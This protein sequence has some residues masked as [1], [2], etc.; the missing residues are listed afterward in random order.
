[1]HEG[2][3]REPERGR[4]GR[5]DADP[6]DEDLEPTGI[7]W[8]LDGYDE[9]EPVTEPTAK[10]ENSLF[11]SF[12]NPDPT[13]ETSD[14]STVWSIQGE[15]ALPPE[16]R[17]PDPVPRGSLPA[18]YFEPPFVSHGADNSFGAADSLGAADSFGADDSLGAASLGEE[19]AEIELEPLSEPPASAPRAASL[20]VGTTRAPNEVMDA[21]ARST[22]H[23]TGDHRSAPPLRRPPRRAPTPSRATFAPPAPSRPGE[24]RTAS[25]ASFTRG[26]SLVE[27]RRRRA[28]RWVA[29]F[30][31]SSFL[32]SVVLCAGAFAML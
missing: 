23:P 17:T 10:F 12:L 9:S 18:S 26:A 31:L 2:G 27:R 29:L 25:R 24:S 8:R 3:S 32:G 22:P 7:E 21:P 4:G 20:R 28:V 19:T 15:P 13:E 16:A 30:A 11:D 5:R 1:M 14:P 6:L